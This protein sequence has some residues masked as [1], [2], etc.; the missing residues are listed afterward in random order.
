VFGVL[1]FLLSLHARF[2]QRS[3]NKSRA[4]RAAYLEVLMCHSTKS[5]EIRFGGVARAASDLYCRP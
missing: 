5:H 3:D 4:E 2:W 1:G